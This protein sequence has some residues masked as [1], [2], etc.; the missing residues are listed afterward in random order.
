MERLNFR[1]FITEHIPLTDAEWALVNTLCGESQLKAGELLLTDGMVCRHLYYVDGGLLRFF[2]WRD[3]V[4]KT[5]FFTFDN[6]L[7]TSQHSF[8]TGTPP[9]KISRPL[10]TP[11]YCKFPTPTCNSSTRKSPAGEN[12]FS[13][14]FSRC[15]ILLSRF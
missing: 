13:E 8:S 12:S 7:F 4:D 2:V 3:G 11:T 14:L 10:N 9:G 1:K 5:K 6:Y 15:I